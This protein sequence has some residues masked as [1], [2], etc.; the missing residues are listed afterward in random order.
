MSTSNVQSIPRTKY[1]VQCTMYNVR[2][3]LARQSQGT[4]PLGKVQSTMYRV[5]STEGMGQCTMYNVQCALYN[6]Q[7]KGT[8]YNVRNFLGARVQCTEY[9]V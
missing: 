7:C 9:R 5:Q 8:M 3:F 2:N 4:D 6:V 1:N